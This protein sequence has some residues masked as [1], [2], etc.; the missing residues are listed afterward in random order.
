MKKI[1]NFF[2]SKKGTVVLA[3]MAFALLLSSAAG[4]TN[5][6]LT[7]YSQ[8]YTAQVSMYDIGVTLVENGTNVS[9]RDYT[10]SNDV[11]NEKTGTL[12]SNMLEE[13]NGKVVVNHKYPEELTV[14]NSGNINEYVRMRVYRYWLDPNGKKTNDLSPALIKLELND[15]KWILDEQT[16]ERLYFYW[17]EVLGIGEKTEAVTKSISID[18]AVSK[19]VTTI[20]QE[21][22]SWKTT[23]DY[24]GY[25][26]VLEAEVDAVQT[27]N[28]EDAIKSAWGVEAATYITEWEDR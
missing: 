17:P 10:G 16:D 15:S 28:A 24:N 11:W 1:V 2:R 19:Y 23:Y 22:G 20:K 25:T 27:H 5:A 8:N 6:A 7:Y 18:G 12:L 26:F 13:T 14:T 3:L 9:Y 4:S 21:D